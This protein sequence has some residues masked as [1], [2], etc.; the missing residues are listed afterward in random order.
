MISIFCR[1]FIEAK[2]SVIF[3]DGATSRDF[4]F[5]ENVIQ[6]NIKA[7]FSESVKK[8][9]VFNI[10]CGEQISLNDIVYALGKLS[11]NPM[12]A[13]YK[14]ERK[15]DVKHS[16]ASIAKAQVKL[17]YQ[18]AINFVDGLEIVYDWY[19]KSGL[20]KYQNESL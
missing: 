17:N 7:M 20:I 14:E 8:H 10:A 1:N 6:A 18:P 13:E 4:T 9:D 16:K 11:G 12:A 2:P 5:V 15:G 19:K 3:G